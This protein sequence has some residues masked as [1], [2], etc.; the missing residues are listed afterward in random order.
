M[1]FRELN[2]WIRK[3]YI[4]PLPLIQEI[5]NK[6]PEYKYFTKID[7]SMQY[8]TFELSDEAKELCVIITPFGKFLYEGAMGIK[9]SPDF[10][11]VVMEDI[12]WDMPN[13]KVCIDDIGI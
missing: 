2:K 7:I 5:L 1:D 9:Q 13:V 11:Q 3:K 12:F 10:A 8:Y 4:Y 6:Q